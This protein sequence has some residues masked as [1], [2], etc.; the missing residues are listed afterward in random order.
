[1]TASEHFYRAHWC[2]EAAKRLAEIAKE[3]EVLFPGTVRAYKAQERVA[4]YVTS[5]AYELAQGFEELG[6]LKVASP[7]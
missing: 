1:M 4:F 5:A 3:E 2:G 6:K 7:S